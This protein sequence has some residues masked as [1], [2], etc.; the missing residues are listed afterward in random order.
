MGEKTLEPKE[1]AERE[2]LV[3]AFC[4]LG[5]RGGP[6]LTLEN[7]K[8]PVASLFSEHLNSFWQVAR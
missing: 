1:T 5:T 2:N 8:D 7:E 3:F 6:L 4:F